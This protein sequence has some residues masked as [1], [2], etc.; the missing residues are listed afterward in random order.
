MK[1]TAWHLHCFQVI[2]IFIYF[3]DC[4]ESG[5]VATLRIRY[6]YFGPLLLGS[7]TC[8]GTMTMYKVTSDQPWSTLMHWS[9]HKISFYNILAIWVIHFPI[10]RMHYVQVYRLFS[11]WIVLIKP[12]QFQSNRLINITALLV[13]SWHFHGPP[14]YVSQT[15]LHYIIHHS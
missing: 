11:H 2:Y 9:M 7:S 14:G 8:F 3:E 15:P 6:D 1:V 5:Y 4:I 10:N 13:V 12:I